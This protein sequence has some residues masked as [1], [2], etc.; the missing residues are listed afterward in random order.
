MAGFYYADFTD[1]HPYY[2]LHF[3]EPLLD[4]WRRDWQPPRPW[5]FGEF[6]DSD[7][8]RDLSEMKQAN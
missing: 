8:F 6:C 2:D 5:I 7:T 4:N 3:F 1:Y